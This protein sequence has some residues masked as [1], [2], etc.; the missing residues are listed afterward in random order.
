MLILSISF[1]LLSLLDLRGKEV[2]V[3]SKTSDERTIILIDTSASMSVED[4]RP[5]RFE[6]ALLLVKHYVRKAVGQKI[7][8]IVFSDGQKT[9][10]PFTDDFNLLNA[11]IETLKNLSLS[12]GGTGLSLAIQES[13][14]YFKDTAEE[15]KGNI[16]IFSDAEENDGGIEISVPASVS[17]AVVGV[18]T[19]RG[20]PIPI[21]NK[22]GVF[23]GNKKF[24]GKEVVSKLNESFLKDLG[25]KIKNYN[26]WIAT[27]YS[28]PTSEILSFFS[29]AADTRDSENQFRIRPVLLEFLLIPAFVFLMLSSLFRMRKAYISSLI[30][31]M[32]LFQ[33]NLS[34]AEEK[35][36]PVKSAKTLAM[37]QAFIQ[38]ELTD[39]EKKAYASSLL[40]DNFPEQAEMLYDEVLK[41]KIDK[42][43]LSHH[44]NKAT[45][46]LKNKKIG[47]AIE[48]YKEILSHLEKNPNEK[49][50]DIEKV[51]KENLLKAL[52]SQQGQGS[53]K[54]EDSDEKDDKKDSKESD[55]SDE[56]K[57]KKDDKKEDGKDQDN[58][59]DEKDKKPDESKNN[60]KDKQKEDKSESSDEKKKRKKKLPALLKQLLSD[61]NKLQKKMIDAE[62]TERKKRDQKD[63]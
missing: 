42:K 56:G 3:N 27:S 7:A 44:F 62:T 24:K 20:G 30:V 53:G 63:W 10:V 41:P 26:F 59:N 54:G 1:F 51:S 33:P 25:K 46:Q 15:P 45:A 18:G 61:D 52:M 55:K 8:V 48:N 38:G 21:R 60:D 11:R 22:Q 31:F 36:E 37:E 32:F 16:L 19:A 14:Q 17:V 5:N 57:P 23:K 28:L 40:E 43:N 4:V 2:Q 35:E 6:K 50:K 29:K 58:K 39:E 47:T 12:R 13:I 34:R 9:I 49:Y